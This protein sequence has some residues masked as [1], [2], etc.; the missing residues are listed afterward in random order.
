VTR[1]KDP[2]RRNRNDGFG[3]IPYSDLS[4]RL[5]QE[6][7]QRFVPFLGAGA[8]RSFT[9]PGEEVVSPI[10]P[11]RLAEIARLLGIQT[12][13]AL[14]LLEIAAGAVRWLD[15][16]PAQPPK[17]YAA[18]R[19]SA[20]APSASDLAQALA[21]RSTYDHLARAKRRVCE[22][23]GRETW[24]D[25]ALT[26]LLAALGG[27]TGLGSAAP[28]LLDASSY[29]AYRKRREEFW[30]DLYGLFENKQQPTSTQQLVALAASNYIQANRDDFTAHD[31][32][33]V[34]TNYDSL[35]ENAL[36]AVQPDPVPYYVLTVPTAEPLRV[37]LRFSSGVRDYLGVNDA[38]FKKI[39]RSA[40]VEPDYTLAK[41]PDQ[42]SGLINTPRPLVT[43]Y[44]I[45]GS[46]HPGATPDT[47]GVVITNED[48]VNFLSVNRVP[49]AIIK[50]LRG[51]SL[52]LLG[53]SFSDWNV[54]SLYRDMTA[55]RVGKGN[56]VT[57]D[58]AVLYDPSPYETGFFD[59]NRIDIVDTTLDVFCQRML[60]QA[61]P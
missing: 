41:T 52:L 6:R 14:L 53:Y 18:V 13:D 28:P 21:E 10:D 57:G 8:S 17:T 40:L 54:R 49:A 25:A 44:K 9:P 50:R 24:T 61:G 15:R 39:A 23:T 29:L 3:D 45:H 58:Y 46:L 20:D 60:A 11:D 37:D 42:F 38:Q 36:Q 2:Q 51:L 4:H 26:R 32:L 1:F 31:F 27:M 35:L 55:Y 5:L 30:G 33:I 16:H 48:Y 19:T 7:E 59:S 43:V 34:T 56:T 22:L 12:P 47:D